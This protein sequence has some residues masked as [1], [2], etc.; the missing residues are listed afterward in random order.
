MLTSVKNTESTPLDVSS[1]FTLESISAGL[2]NIKL[3]SGFVQNAFYTGN[4]NLRVWIFSFTA[5]ING[6]T[7]IIEKTIALKNVT[8]IMVPSGVLTI[9]TDGSSSNLTILVATNG[10]SSLNPNRGKEINWFI[11]SQTGSSAG[12]V[13]YFSLSF[14]NTNTL[15]TCNVINDNVGTLDPD[16]YTV[17]VRA[18]D[19]GGAYDEIVLT[20]NNS[21]QIVYVREYT[22]TI[23]FDEYYFTEI[24]AID[25]T[26]ENKSGFYAFLGTW[27]ELAV[28]GVIEIDYTNSAKIGCPTSPNKWIF[29]YSSTEGASI[30]QATECLIQD[31][32]HDSSYITID[33]SPYTFDI[34]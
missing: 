3:T 31:Q 32:F 7:N 13:N 25:S 33:A 8:P 22:L 4:Q 5:I 6:I 17:I 21:V 23:G 2:Y 12:V 19:A 15:S 9:D 34:V 11:H 16:V 20:I 14:S 28:P 30:A 26:D 1:Y 27:G 24:N 10:A 18:E 29:K